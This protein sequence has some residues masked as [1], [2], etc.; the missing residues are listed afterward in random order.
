MRSFWLDEEIEILRSNYPSKTKKEM[1]SLL[2]HK[3]Q[4]SI[5]HKAHRIG[6]SKTFYFW[7]DDELRILRDNWA[8]KSRPEVLA[9]LPNKDWCS[10]RHKAF[11]LHL[12][13]TPRA[14]YWRTYAKIVPSSQ[15]TERLDSVPQLILS[16]VDWAYLAGI[17]DGEGTVRIMKVT[18]GHYAPFVQI[19]NT[20]IKLM[21]WLNHIFGGHVGGHIYRKKQIPDSPNKICY[22]Y[23]ITKSV[24]IKQVLILTM[25]YL[26]LKQEQAKLVL[27]LIQVKQDKKVLGIMEKEHELYKQ[28]RILNAVGTKPVV[29]S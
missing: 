27:A 20:N 7:N 9:L 22:N 3:S 14:K 23:N 12:I 18:G 13:K 10:V 5:M 1:L 19:A 25:D 21:D 8:T 2:P 29:F 6:I 4:S 16:D 11:D 17:I 26:K 28:C 24:M 15:M